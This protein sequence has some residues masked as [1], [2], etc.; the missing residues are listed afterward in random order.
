MS[1][2]QGARW[3]IPR[4]DEGH[5]EAVSFADEGGSYEGHIEWEMVLPAYFADLNGNATPE[6]YAE[7]V[8]GLCTSRSGTRSGPS[9]A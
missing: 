8:S 6:E 2:F 9:R 1:L 4:I 7:V 3:L 5:E